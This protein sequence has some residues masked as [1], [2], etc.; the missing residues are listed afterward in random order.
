MATSLNARQLAKYYDDYKDTEITFTKDILRTLAMDPRQIYI[1]CAGNQWPCILN[2]TSFTKAKIIIG[3]KGGAYQQLQQNKDQNLNLRFSFYT[4][5][6]Q[7][8][9]FFTTG[10]ATET[11][12][13]MNSNDLAIV[14]ITY[15]QRPPDDL[16][17]M[18]GHLLDANTNAVRRKEDRIVINA[19]TCR[20]LG[21][22]REETII[23]IQG[24]PRHC[25]LRDISFG[26]T[27]VILLGLSQFLMNK[28]VTLR[29]EF[30]EPHE[31]IQLKG[32]ILG[33]SPIE[34]RKDMVAANIRFD[35][36]S[37]SLA[38]KIHINNYL[39]S[40]RIDQLDNANVI[41]KQLTASELQERAKEQA[42]M[43]KRAE[44]QKR[45]EASAAKDNPAPADS[46]APAQPQPQQQQPQQ[47]IPAAAAKLAGTIK[48]I[49]AKLK[50]ATLTPEQRSQLEKAFIAA[51]TQY[52]TIMAK[53]GQ[54][55]Q[56]SS[57][58]PAEPQ[59]EAKTEEQDQTSTEEITDSDNIF[60]LPDL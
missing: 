51:K 15:S 7:L 35:E 55:I 56:P 44:E 4:P 24:V 9:G 36:S 25:I 16:I 47:Q 40:T 53:S 6:G 5:D 48:L 33:T 34:G 30:E 52:Q 21:L 50:T 18:V 26:G 45:A 12:S 41:T 39:T 3:T 20:K 60:D 58:A 29:L 43:D 17:D 22:P 19:D 46:A 8:K 31:I 1:K 54:S 11:T 23:T 42:I 57:P 13:Y 10:K 59:K 49:A 37:I 2:S 28:E 38:Y 32:L 27:K 14:T